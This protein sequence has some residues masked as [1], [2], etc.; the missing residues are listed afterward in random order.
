MLHESLLQNTKILTLCERLPTS[1]LDWDY[2]KAAVGISNAVPLLAFIHHRRLPSTL[3]WASFTTEDGCQNFNKFRATSLSRNRRQMLI[4]QMLK[5]SKEYKLVLSQMNVN[6]NMQLLWQAREERGKG[7][8]K[9]CLCI[10]PHWNQAMKN[11]VLPFT[12]SKSYSS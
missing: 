12:R 1:I 7:S 11:L 4:P 2:H 5:V 9:S 10:L 6:S 3:S 8:K